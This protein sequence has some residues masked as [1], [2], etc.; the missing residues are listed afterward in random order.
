MTGGTTTRRL[1]AGDRLVVASHNAGKVW[2]IRTLIAPFG[3]TAT[4][5]AD[6]GLPEPD[7]TETSFAGNA[8]LKAHAAASASGSPAL[9]DDSGL[10]V[11]CLGG[12]PGVYSARWAGPGRDFGHAMRKVAE[13]IGAR[14]GWA[15]PG[16]RA[17]FVCVLALAWPDGDEALFEGRVEGTLVW[18]PRGGNGFG[19]DPMFVPDDYDVTFGE[20]EPAAKNA[21]SHRARAFAAFRDACLG[22]PLTGAATMGAATT[23]A[24]TGPSTGIPTA[25]EALAAAAAAVSTREEFL[26]FVANLRTDLATDPADWENTTLD[27]Y[28]DGLGGHLTG[29]T[30][31]EE[32]VWRT[33][34]KVL[35]A[36]GRHA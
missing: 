1:T 13:E 32:P 20:M 31:P 26:R 17:A 28:L 19:Y 11:D 29:A 5:A 10:A 8:L 33:L 12:A 18:P 6:L 2:E 24:T 16:P 27:R 14:H 21:M 7:E 9:A 35:Y 30:I 3:L 34:A 36:A 22:A 23:G 4:S 25:R 15:A